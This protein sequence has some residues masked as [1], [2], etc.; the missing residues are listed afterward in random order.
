MG[1]GYSS[2]L[3]S[4]VSVALGLLDPM[5]VLSFIVHGRPI[6]ATGYELSFIFDTVPGDPLV[7][8]AVSL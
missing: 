7:D 5:G 1:P 2:G 6:G 3:T 4:E 8:R